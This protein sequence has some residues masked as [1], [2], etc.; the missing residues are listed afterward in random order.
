[1]EISTFQPEN[2]KERGHSGDLDVDGRTILEC[3]PN[4]VSDTWEDPLA[5]FCKPNQGK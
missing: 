2:I 1:M 5:I 3:I 4:M